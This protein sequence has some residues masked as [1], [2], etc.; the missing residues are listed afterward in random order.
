MRH[1]GEPVSVDA[2]SLLTPILFADLA[3]EDRARPSLV[4]HTDHGTLQHAWMTRARTGIVGLFR[5]SLDF[6]V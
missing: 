6:S 4:R 5:A 3:I 1:V 2:A